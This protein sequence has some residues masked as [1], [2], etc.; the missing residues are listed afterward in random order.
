VQ[1]EINYIATQYKVI[2]SNEIKVAKIINQKF[3]CFWALFKDRENN[4]KCVS[5]EINYVVSQYRAI[6]SN[7]KKLQ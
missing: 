5:L 4:Y 6:Y 1:L 3:A 7:K 2:Y